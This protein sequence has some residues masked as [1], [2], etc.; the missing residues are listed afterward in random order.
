MANDIFT[1]LLRGVHTGEGH[2]GTVSNH[3]AIRQDTNDE[4]DEESL[5]F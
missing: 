5:W 2:S 4:D 1:G 3:H